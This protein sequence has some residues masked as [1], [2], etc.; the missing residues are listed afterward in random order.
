MASKDRLVEM[1]DIHKDFGR[2]TA[3]NGVNLDLYEDE[4]LSIVGDNGSG[5]S[6]LIKTLVGLH[7]PDS[8][9]I[10][11]RGELV[12]MTDPKEARKYGIET[13][14]QDLALVNTMSVAANMFLDR[15]PMKKLGL[16]D[17]IDWEEMAERS[18]SIL[19]KRLNIHIDPTSNVEY[20]SGGERQAVAIGRALTTNP[21]I[22]VLDE[23]TSALS[24]D[25]AERVIDLIRSLRNEGVS[26]I[27]ISHNLSHVFEISDRITILS[28]GDY[29]GTVNTSETDQTTV[30]RMIV[31]GKDIR[32]T[33]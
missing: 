9:E 26:V 13:V 27:I 18:A 33:A 22:V 31:E 17:V 32:T 11:V 14:Y 3:L 6:T 8:G 20:L 1:S 19:E 21:D 24:P 5:K 12:Q 28:D 10:R 2:V 15:Y 23:P 7:Q 4:V 16:I 25:A 30:G 29:V